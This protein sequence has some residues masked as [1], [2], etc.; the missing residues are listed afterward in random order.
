M[1]ILSYGVAL[2]Q[3][4]PTLMAETRQ[5]CTVTPL[6]SPSNSVV[7]SSVVSS[8]S[9]VLPGNAAL[10]NPCIVWSS[11]KKSSVGDF[12]EKISRSVMPKL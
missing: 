5:S 2:V 4:S 7:T 10:T 11:S 12:P 1:L 3:L 8:T 6:Q 9:S